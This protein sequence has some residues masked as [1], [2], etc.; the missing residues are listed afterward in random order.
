M[1][2]NYY[3]HLDEDDQWFI[4][5]V[6]EELAE[7]EKSEANNQK[8]NDLIRGG[9]RPSAQEDDQEEE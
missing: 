7:R 6:G 3:E 1:T 5:D 8:M 4:E 2:E 9:F